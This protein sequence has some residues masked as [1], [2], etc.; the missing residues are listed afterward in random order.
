MIGKKSIEIQQPWELLRAIQL[1]NGEN[2][3]FPAGV[4]Y[5]SNLSTFVFDSNGEMFS[6]GPVLTS[7]DETRILPEY[8]HLYRNHH[9][10]YVF[11]GTHVYFDTVSDPMYNYKAILCMRDTLSNS[12]SLGGS[13]CREMNFVETLV[14]TSGEMI[15]VYASAL[16]NTK[17]RN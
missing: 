12:H 2:I 6:S 17:F 8:L 7:V 13:C 14:N 1:V 5:N 3:K 9:L 15:Y 10:R 16:F 11:D 4:H